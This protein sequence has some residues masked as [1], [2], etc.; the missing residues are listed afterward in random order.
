MHDSLHL[1]FPLLSSV[2][3]VLAA[4]YARTAT[5]LGVT[6]YTATALSN[7]TLAVIWLIIGLTQ[8]AW[9][10]IG[11]WWQ[12][13]WIGAAFVSGQ[14]ATYLAF[15]LGDVSLATPVFGVK[16]IMVAFM[17]SMLA[18]QGITVS[19]WIAAALA[20]LGVAVIQF[21]ASANSETKL[22]ARR[23]AFSIG[24]ALL[25]ATLLSIFDI[26]VQRAGKEHGALPFLSTMFVSVGVLS[27]G[28]L[29]WTNSVAQIR[30]IG[31]TKPLLLAAGFMAA[32]GLSVTYALGQFGDATRINIVYSL[33]GLWSVLFAWIAARCFAKS[34]S[35]MSRST[36]LYRFIGAV[37]VTLAILIALIR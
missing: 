23:A 11:A 18:D 17:S 35:G 30:S 8:D 4:T 27:V 36:L 21:G 28:L 16:I 12:A 15:R 3:F 1:V 34:G 33:R 31:A 24:F 32:Q 9:I 2:L 37:M 25:A 26:A 7:F 29:P 6:P 22:T 14:L 13:I 20:T 5:S 10:P 19:I